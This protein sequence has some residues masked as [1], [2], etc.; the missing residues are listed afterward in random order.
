MLLLS[1]KEEREEWDQIKIKSAKEKIKRRES[2]HML[3]NIKCCSGVF[4]WFI[5]ILLKISAEGGKF[6]STTQSFMNGRHFHSWSIS[7][8]AYQKNLSNVFHYLII[9]GVT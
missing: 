2:S 5:F 6:E 8:I 4:S 9:I 3:C 7:Q 1:K